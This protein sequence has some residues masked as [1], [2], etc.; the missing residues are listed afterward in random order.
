MRLS[1]FIAPR[2]LAY[3]AEQHAIPQSWR[4]R[5]NSLPERYLQ[6]KLFRWK[7]LQR[8]LTGNLLKT[9]NFFAETGFIFPGAEADS[10]LV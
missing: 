5:P 3:R 10:V 8:N 6:L 1:Q 9:G 7:Y 2:V 4:N